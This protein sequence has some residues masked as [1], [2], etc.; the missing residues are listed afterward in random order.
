MS[1]SCPGRISEE[2]IT[3]M[4]AGL[5]HWVDGGNAGNLTWGIF[6]AVKG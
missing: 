2:Y 5:Q 1:R 4:K 3:K 6:H